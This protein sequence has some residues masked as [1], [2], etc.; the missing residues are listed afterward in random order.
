MYGSTTG[1]AESSAVQSGA[2]GSSGLAGNSVNQM[3]MSHSNPDLT[4][5][6]YE[7]P[8]ADY[9]EHALKVFKADQTSKYLLIHKVRDCNF[10]HPHPPIECI[11]FLFF[12]N[13]IGNYCPGGRDALLAGIS[14][15]GSVVQ[16]QF[17]R[18]DCDGQR[19]N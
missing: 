1:S 7:D 8:R 2:V 11:S 10:N 4:S 14:N 19:H 9:P 6:C 18:S 16:L 15:Y 13:L 3:Y 17:V 5:I 12:G